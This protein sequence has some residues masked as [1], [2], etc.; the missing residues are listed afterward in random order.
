MSE[1]ETKRITFNT[2]KVVHDEFRTTCKG[3]KKSMSRVITHLM[4]E[5]NRE[6][7]E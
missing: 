7:A 6:N 3:M 4:R 5:Y 2:P 1:I